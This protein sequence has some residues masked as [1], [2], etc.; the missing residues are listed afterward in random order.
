MKQTIIKAIK[1]LWEIIKFYLWYKPISKPPKEQP[2]RVKGEQVFDD[3]MVLTYHKQRINVH[4]SEY[5][6][7]KLSSR[8]DKRATA[9][10][11]RVLE[12]KGYIRFEEINGKLICLKN[13]NY[14][15][16]A[17]KQKK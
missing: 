8:A 15:E 17:D 13:K 11:Y 3:Y 7:W 4:K 6:I 1:R 14:Q 16:L 12:K 2:L 5:E 10:R 9:E